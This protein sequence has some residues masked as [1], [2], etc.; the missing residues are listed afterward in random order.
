MEKFNKLYQD[1]TV[2]VYREKFEELKTL[3]LI[4]NPHLSEDYFI[5]SF[6][7]GLKKEIKTIVKMLKLGTLSEVV[8]VAHLQEQALKLQGKTVKNGSRIV[9]EPRF[10][11]FRHPTPAN[12]EV[13]NYKL[14]RGSTPR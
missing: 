13:S 7:S 9:A 11:M 3:M 12:A 1:I 5:S 10:G 4:R 8:E 14:S 6:T 2:E